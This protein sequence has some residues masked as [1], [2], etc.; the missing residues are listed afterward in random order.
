[1]S[2]IT[3][4]FFTNICNAQ[5]LSEQLFPDHLKLAV[6]TPVFK[7][8]DNNLT[9]NYRPVIVLHVV[10]KA[11]ERKLQKIIIPYYDQFLSTFLWG[12][13]KSYS[14]QTLHEKWSILLRILSVNGTKSAEKCGFADIYWK[15]P[16]WRT[17]LCSETAL[18]SMLEK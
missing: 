11:F 17:F 8:E 1:M 10:S 9:K 3:A 4:S 2:E 16:E 14:N 18:I 15:N 5:T 13:R 7:K 12:Y 6:T